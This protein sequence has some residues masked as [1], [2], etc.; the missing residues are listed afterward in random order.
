M[1]QS[2][3]SKFKYIVA[4]KIKKNPYSWSLIWNILP[5]I[6]FLLPHDKSYFGFRHLVTL[7]TGL[8]LD[9]GGNNGMTAAGFR[10]INCT[11]EIL[12]IEPNP[13]HEPALRRL[14]KRL[15]RFDYRILAAGDVRS[16]IV[17]YTP[18]Y[19][20]IPL[21]AHTSTSLEYLKVSVERDFSPKIVA[22]ITYDKQAVPVIPL[23]ELDLQPA[24]VKIDAEGYDMHVLQGLQQTIGRYR[25]SFLIEYTPKLMGAF[26]S[27]FSKRHYALFSYD[28]ARDVFLLFDKAREVRT[29]ET[30]GLQVNIFCIPEE[31]AGGLPRLLNAEQGMN[32][33]LA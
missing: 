28:Q 31:K 18:I 26:E 8:F 24:I 2:L 11:Y 19:K 20:K 6:G 29:W 3:Y 1:K 21:H 12:S 33:T 16:E 17:L 30:N 4:E 27:F 32:Q 14:K 23:D 10:K 15:T 13:C 5:Y 9:V 25:P 22:S 7:P